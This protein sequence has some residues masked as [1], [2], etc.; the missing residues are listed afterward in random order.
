VKWEY[1]LGKLGLPEEQRD[2]L[3]NQIHAYY[4]AV[5]RMF[6]HAMLLPPQ[7]S[8]RLPIAERIL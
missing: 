5:G 3:E 8:D 4:R 6:A 2:L 7:D 1:A